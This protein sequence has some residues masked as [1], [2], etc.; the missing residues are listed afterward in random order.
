[1]QN[2]YASFWRRLVAFII[3]NIVISFPTM[4]LSGVV[5]ALFMPQLLSSMEAEPS[6]ETIYALFSTYGFVMLLNLV[7]ALFFGS[8]MRL[9]KAVP[10]RLL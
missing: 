1:M 10:N 7:S 6:P 8:T 4:L 3:D 9:W 2:V 5:A